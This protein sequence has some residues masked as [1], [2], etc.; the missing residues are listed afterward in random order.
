MKEINLKIKKIISCL[1]L[2]ALS[3]GVI[4]CAN[5]SEPKGD[6]ISI[7][8]VSNSETKVEQH[9]YYFEEQGF[10]ARLEE[11]LQ[12]MGTMP[13]KVE[14]KPPLLMGF[15]LLDYE[16]SNGRLNLNVSTEYSSLE[17]TVEILVRAAL[18]RTLTQFKEI[19]YV[20]ITVAGNR[21]YDNANEQIGWMSADKFIDNDGNEINTYDQIKVKL[22]FA[23]S[24]GDMLIAAYREKYYSTNTP[25]EKFVVDE[26]IAGPSGQ[27]PGLYPTINPD[28]KII[29][30]T[31]RDGICY[32]NFDSSFL[33]LTNNVSLESSIYSV[34]NSLAELSTV[35]KVQILVN[36]EVPK[37]IGTTVFERNLDNV[38][39]L[40]EE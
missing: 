4:G 21:L 9:L 11:I 5:S 28:T 8:Y 10:E 19:S 2:V 14:Y 23:N 15:S 34:V 13:Y 20:G 22:Y 40:E 6:S 16:Y 7:Y 30:I 39:T 29:S 24:T 26:L 36:G 37:S 1:L 18:V 33:T 31:T 27:I 25:I 17:P 35:N 32:V 12:C 3:L 38:T